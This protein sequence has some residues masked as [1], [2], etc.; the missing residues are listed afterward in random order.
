[1][2]RADG[3]GRSPRPWRLLLLTT[4]IL[5]AAGVVL[6]VPDRGMRPQQTPSAAMSP[7]VGTS[8]PAPPLSA[9]PVST[10]APHSATAPATAT[11]T[12]ASQLPPQ[13]ENAAGDAV[14]QTALEAAWPADLPAHDEVQLLAAGRDLLRADA[15]G[16]GRGRW[17]GVFA[18]AGQ[19]L[20]PA[21]GSGRFRV[22]AAIARRDGGPDRAV[23]HLVWAGADRGGTFT[24]GRIADW[25][26]TRIT[27]QKGV[28]SW[29]ARSRI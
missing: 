10:R 3:T 13:G 18:S 28:T 1:M 23:V 25:H 29:R 14:I 27:S 2:T 12:G 21:F 7:T 26:F 6:L 9:M 17:P 11:A 5:T 20:A 16:F 8:L 15:T 4:V 24:D 19:V 22:Q